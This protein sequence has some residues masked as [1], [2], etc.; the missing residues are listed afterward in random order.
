[1]DPLAHRGNSAKT[2]TKVDNAIGISRPEHGLSLHFKVA[3][4]YVVRQLPDCRRSCL[5]LIDHLDRPQFF[6]VLIRR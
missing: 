1:M 4:L 2:L 6:S 3:T 5:V